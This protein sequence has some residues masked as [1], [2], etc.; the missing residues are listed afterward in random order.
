MLY[1]VGED[2]RLMT[3]V[4]LNSAGILWDYHQMK[5]RPEKADL[6]F[7]LGSHDLRVA[8]HGAALFLEGLAPWIL[9]SGGI[10]HQGDMLETGWTKSEAEMFADRAEEAGVPRNRMILECQAGNTGENVSNSEKILKA[11]NIPHQRILAVQKPYMERRAY[12]TI[13]VYWPEKELSVTSPPLNFEEY[14]NNEIS[15]DELIHIMVGDMQRIIEYPAKG[16]QIQQHVPGSVL[17]AYK[18]LLDAGFTSHL[19]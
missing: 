17:A 18:N 19:I 16:Y 12:A 7:V 8:D 15:R 5:H 3:Q 9:F 6:I 14:P 1:K 4:E 10:A 13:K 11:G 2:E